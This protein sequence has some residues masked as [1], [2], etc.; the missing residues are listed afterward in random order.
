MT[1]TK[2]Y[3]SIARNGARFTDTT[4]QLAWERALT[5]DCTDNP[6]DEIVVREE[7]FRKVSG[8]V[9]YQRDVDG[10]VNEAQT[11]HLIKQGIRRIRELSSNLEI[12]KIG[13]EIEHHLLATHHV[14]PSI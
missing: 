9:L 8:T 4:E 10:D 1:A 6:I 5:A 12:Q 11:K 13:A 7:S 14:T 2:T 3:T